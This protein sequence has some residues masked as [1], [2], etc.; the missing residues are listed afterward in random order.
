MPEIEL[1]ALT[2][3]YDGKVDVLKAIDLTMKDG[4]FTVLVGPSGCGK[5]T[6]LRLI[7]GGI[8][9]RRGNFGG[10]Q[11]D[12]QQSAKRPQHGDGVSELRPIPPYECGGQYRLFIK[13]RRGG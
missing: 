8:P 1:K 2:K 12:H 7:A 10:R 3:S 9:D 4:E 6:T 5:S 11:T 13:N